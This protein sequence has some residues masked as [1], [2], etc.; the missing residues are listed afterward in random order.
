[1]RLRTL[2]PALACLAAAPLAS[3]ADSVSAVKVDGFVDS[4]LSGSSLIDS[5]PEDNASNTAFSYAAKLGVTA[6]ISDKVSAKVEAFIDGDTISATSGDDSIEVTQAYGSWKITNDVTL[7]T[8][9]FISDYGWV[10]Y[11]APG[12]Y[13][14]N[15]GPIF[16]LYGSNQVGANVSYTKDALTAALTVAN[17]FFDEDYN[18]EA[19][20]GSSQKDQAMFYGLDVIYDLA[21]KGSVNAELGYDMDSNAP[22]GDGIYA[23][24]N[25][26]FTPNEQITAGAEIVYNSVGA[27]DPAAATADDETSLGFLA[28]VN[29]KLGATFPVPAS[30]TGMVQYV[31]T[32]NT[33]NVKGDTEE[34][35]ELSVALLT[36]PAGTDKLGANLEISYLTGEEEVS[37]VTTEA[38]TVT[39][40]AELLYVF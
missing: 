15:A 8:G 35:L 28:M 32:D 12:L 4:V 7:K 33:S 10:A 19:Q 37:N 26:T 11:Y 23:N 6:T 39:V 27:T 16:D 34:A 17:G 1:M 13:R 30:V 2:V 20:S 25:A 5:D 9:K 22:G 38:S 3:A 18:S 31:S 40:A 14:V 24:L 36:N 29:Y 21:G